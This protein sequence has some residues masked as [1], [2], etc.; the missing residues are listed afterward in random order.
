MDRHS[1]SPAVDATASAGRTPTSAAR[2]AL[3]VAVTAGVLHGLASLYWA[4]GGTW[5]ISTLGEDLVQ[6]FSGIRW[7]L[8]P[9]GAVKVGFA[10]APAV[11]A[12]MG[13]PWRRVS[14]A[15]CW[16]GAAVLTGWGSLNTIAANLVLAGVITPASDYDRAGMIGHA[17]LWDPLFLVWGVALT[18]A[19]LLTREKP[20]SARR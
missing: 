15:L 11:L 20:L 5:L 1:D 13:W 9:I 4:G 7:V 3:G 2:A 19:L 10:C 17:A 6:R 14:R 16:L 8:F 12:S 18:T